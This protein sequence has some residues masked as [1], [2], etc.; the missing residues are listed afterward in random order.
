VRG[1]FAA[2]DASAWGEFWVM[3]AMSDMDE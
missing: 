2:A 3:L 1:A